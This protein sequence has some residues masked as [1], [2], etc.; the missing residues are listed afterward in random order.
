[1]PGVAQRV[2]RGINLLFHYSTLEGGEWSAARPC[3]ILPP[4][5]TRYTL[6]RRLYGPHVRSGPARKISPQPAFDPRTVLPVVSRYTVWATRSIWFGIY[7]IENTWEV[8]VALFHIY[9]IPTVR[10]DSGKWEEVTFSIVVPCI[11][12]SSKSFIYQQMNY[13]LIL[14]NYKIYIKT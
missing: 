12:I 11:L 10:R 7:D 4:G 3:H 13:L 5:K 14:E 1:M 2:G 8:F 9:R 6:Y